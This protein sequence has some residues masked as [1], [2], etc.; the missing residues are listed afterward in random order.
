MAA[1]DLTKTTIEAIP[2]TGS[3]RTTI[4]VGDDGIA[5]I[6][7]EVRDRAYKNH[8]Y[9]C[10]LAAFVADNPSAAG[11]ITTVQTTAK[12]YFD[13]KLLFVPPA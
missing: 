13:G 3:R 4:E 2:A 8:V 12:T 7:Y 1:D 9:R 11:A 10:T 6:T 5:W